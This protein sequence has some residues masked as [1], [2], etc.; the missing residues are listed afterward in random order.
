MSIT[1][2]TPIG[3]VVK[4][5]YKSKAPQFKGKSKAKKREMAVAAALSKQ[6][7]KK[8]TKEE[9]KELVRK[10]M[11]EVTMVDKQT[12]SDEAA[13]IAKQE[14][15]DINTVKTAI[16]TAKKTGKPVSVAEASKTPKYD[17]NPTLKGGQKNLPDGLQAGIIRAAKKKGV[18]SEAV[19]YFPDE[20]GEFERIDT[21]DKDPTQ[22]GLDRLLQR[23][24]N[25]D[26]G[27]DLDIGHQDNEPGMLRI[28]LYR[29]A[30]YAKELGNMVKELEQLDG[31]VDFPHWWQEKII[32]AKNDL[33]T[34]KHYLDGSLQTGQAFN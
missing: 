25:Q 31:E 11:A 26:L 27:E 22:V 2:K 17:D 4:D 16:D 5:F 14:K 21:G 33:V 19:A 29:I 1:K 3:S 30:K 6:D 20:E 7:N 28:D 10:T 9:L 34:A 24:K 23:F 13:T 32:K 18:K 12:T 15:K 8:M